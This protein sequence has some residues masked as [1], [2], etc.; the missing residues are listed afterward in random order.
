[1]FVFVCVLCDELDQKP[2][3]QVTSLVGKVEWA[4]AGVANPNKR[5]K[6]GLCTHPVWQIADVRLR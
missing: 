3:W 6:C 2:Y 1:M 4:G 5:R